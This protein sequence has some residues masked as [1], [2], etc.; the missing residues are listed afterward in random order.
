MV[1]KPRVRGFICVT[2]HPAGCEANV[3][4][5]IDYVKAQGPFN[6][7]KRVLVIGASTG[8]GLAARI[9]A[10]FASGAATVGVFLER[11]GEGSK[12]GTAGWYNSAAFHKLA[13]AEDLYASSVNGDAFSDAVKQQTI[14]IIKRD[15]GQVD[16]V[17]Y[18]LAAPRRTHPKTGHVYNSTLKPIGKTLHQRGLDTD[19]EVVKE[20]VIE[21]ATDEEIANTVAVMGGE[22]WQ[23]WIEALDQ[24][25][26]LAEGA[27]TTAFTYL[28]EKITHDIYWNGTIG[29][30]KKDLDQRVL[31]IREQLAAKRG[32]A[33]VAVLKAL[34][35]QASSAIPMMPLYLS[36]LFK[37]M[38]QA[39]T[40]EGCI[41]QV[42]GLYRDSLYNDKPIVDED[43]RLR[44]D[45]K[46]L[47]PAIQDEVVALWDKVTDE[48]LYELTD[49]AGYKSDFLKLFGF[50]VEGVDYEADVNPEVPISKLAQV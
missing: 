44:A 8:Y 13:E 19:K 28:G 3:Q 6:G 25:G 34:V 21:P 1:I 22:D 7:P 33:R 46:E 14:D 37:V 40:H 31:Q 9:S 29:A 23:M 18:S 50:G 48:N 26:V 27:K 36:L 41:E 35:T 16:L 11:A 32:D 30:A 47:A 17:V 2:A 49:F 43:G 45:Y 5:Q 24:A 20:N 10:A 42:D 38:K 12:P 15:L 39:G 4:Q